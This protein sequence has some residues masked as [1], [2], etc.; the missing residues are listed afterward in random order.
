MA[1]GAA[2]NVILPFTVAPSNI[3][4]STIV[5]GGLTVN[6]QISANQYVA[7]FNGTNL[8][9]AYTFD[10]VGTST[11]MYLGGATS[12]AF[13]FGGTLIGAFVY[14]S[15]AAQPSV[16]ALMIANAGINN[17]VYMA[18]SPSA[19]GGFQF[20]AADAT[21][22]TGILASSFRVSA[23]S[24]NQGLFVSTTAGYVFDT[25]GDPAILSLSAIGTYAATWERSTGGQYYCKPGLLQQATTTVVP[26]VARS[27]AHVT[28]LIAGLTTVFVTLPTSIAGVKYTITNVN[29]AS[30]TVVVNP[31]AADTINVFG[32]AKAAG[33]S[34]AANLPF[35][36]ITLH[37]V[38]STMWV[39][40]D[41]VGTWI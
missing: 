23:A 22:A 33:A 27:L 37:C 19:L 7:L 41:F 18:S 32:L 1:Q 10:G 20:F 29:S 6:G 25:N 36:S 9:P 31:V 14:R 15:F 30:N 5:A 40:T 39:A 38:T 28:N 8:A 3:V 2:Y 13:A 24:S 34:V 21:T 12:L 4:P 16:P 35:S 11:G 17:A 26:S